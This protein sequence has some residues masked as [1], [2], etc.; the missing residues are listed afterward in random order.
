MPIAVI[1]RMPTTPGRSPRNRTATIEESNGGNL[2]CCKRV[3]IRPILGR[4]TPGILSHLHLFMKQLFN[5]R[6]IFKDIFY[7]V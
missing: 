4:L 2:E 3:Q 6:S 1:P 5:I 7:H